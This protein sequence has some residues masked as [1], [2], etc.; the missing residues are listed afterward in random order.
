MDVMSELDGSVDSRRESQNGSQIEGA[1]NSDSRHHS[2]QAISS[3]QRAARRTLIN[4]AGMRKTS[5]AAL[6]DEEGVTS[7]DAMF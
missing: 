2:G 5:F 3:L 7:M 4:F 6:P 1:S